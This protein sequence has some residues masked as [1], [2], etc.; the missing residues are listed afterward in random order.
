[1]R[2]T[3]M[4]DERKRATNPPKGAGST[5]TGLM[6]TDRDGWV[7]T[8]YTQLGSQ[9]RGTEQEQQL[10]NIWPIKYTN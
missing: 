4:T 5:A 2:V 9:L 7:P 1:M 10:Y 6:E 3:E 8:G